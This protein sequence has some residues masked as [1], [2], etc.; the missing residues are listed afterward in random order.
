MRV[1]LQSSAHNIVLGKSIREANTTSF[2]LYQNF[3]LAGQ[4]KRYILDD[5]WLPLGLEDGMLV[6][7]WQCHCG[8][9][10]LVMYEND[11]CK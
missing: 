3:T 1:I 6:S 10:W 8:C 7:L 5:E 9:G 4:L 11:F 2:D